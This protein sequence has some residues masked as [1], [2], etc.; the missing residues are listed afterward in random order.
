M[1][2]SASVFSKSLR[3]ESRDGKT[4]TLQ[5]LLYLHQDVKLIKIS[6]D[7]MQMPEDARVQR[8]FVEPDKSVLK[9]ESGLPRHASQPNLCLLDEGLESYVQNVSRAEYLKWKV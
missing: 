2:G 5:R 3:E 9:R 6:L 4:E 7:A 8:S 1:V